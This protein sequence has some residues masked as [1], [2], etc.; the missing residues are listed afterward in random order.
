MVAF[1]EINKIK[2]Y[3]YHTQ[4]QALSGVSKFLDFSG[5]PVITY[6]HI[7]FSWKERF[8]KRL[9]DVLVSVILIICLSPLFIIVYCWIK[10]VSPQGS[11]I[12]TQKRVGRFQKE[13]TLYKFRTMPLN[14]E[15]KTGPSWTLKSNSTTFIKGGQLLR[16]YSI[17]ELP[18]L[19]NI[20]KNEMFLVPYIMVMYLFFTTISTPSNSIIF[21]FNLSQFLTTDLFNFEV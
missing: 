8:I 18:Q 6:Q 3:L 16:R 13:F 4:S 9:I 14:K 17:D 21:S 11:P 12:F 5:I 19:V 15:D 2:I 10:C 20:L 7:N 1:C